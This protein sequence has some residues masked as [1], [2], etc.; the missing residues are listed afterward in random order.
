MSDFWMI[1]ERVEIEILLFLLLA[2]KQFLPT[3]ATTN[4]SLILAAS[5]IEKYA[6]VIDKA[7]DYA[8]KHAK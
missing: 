7:V 2:I 4:P 6:S 3:D 5:K 1:V 8:K